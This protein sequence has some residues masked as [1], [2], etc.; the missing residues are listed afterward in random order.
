M[1]RFSL[2]RLRRH[3]FWSLWR[4][5]A[6]LVFANKYSWYVANF[7]NRRNTCINL[8][9]A[10]HPGGSQFLHIQIYSA[11]H[12]FLL[13]VLWVLRV[14]VHP[15]GLYLQRH[16]FQGL[17]YLGDQWLQ[18]Y[19]HNCQSRRYVFNWYCLNYKICIPNLQLR[20]VLC[21]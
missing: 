9:V 15:A 20:T 6:L 16:L 8:E 7:L 18:K 12:R 19:C 1:Y 3:T 14:P 11:S 10:P 21:N 5:V 2:L 4:I 13:P 17:Q